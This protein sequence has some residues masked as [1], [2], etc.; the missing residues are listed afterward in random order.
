VIPHGLLFISLEGLRFDGRTFPDGKKAEM[1][2]NV[3]EVKK[4]LNTVE[5]MAQEGLN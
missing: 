4:E 3:V 2:D 5:D 1:D